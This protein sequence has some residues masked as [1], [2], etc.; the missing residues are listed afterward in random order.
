MKDTAHQPRKAPK[1]KSLKKEIVLLCSCC[2]AVLVFSLSTFNTSFFLYPNKVLGASSKNVK[3][4]EE[5]SYW[6]ELLSQYPNYIEGWI[7]LAK[8]ELKSGN[9]P[10]A[11]YALNKAKE[12]DPNSQEIKELESSLGL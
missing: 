6:Q 4:E 8:V 7:E 11:I 9:H 2:T 10:A 5:K 1:K 3:A 12:I